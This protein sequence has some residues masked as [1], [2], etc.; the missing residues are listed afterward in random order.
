[1]G[2]K[3]SPAPARK[4]L[5]GDAPLE[6]IASQS[7]QG[8]LFQPRGQRDAAVVRRDLEQPAGR[9]FGPHSRG[10]PLAGTRGETTTGGIVPVR[11]GCPRTCPDSGTETA[12]LGTIGTA[13]ASAAQR[14]GDVETSELDSSPSFFVGSVGD[15]TSASRSLESPN[16]SSRTPTLSN[17]DRYRLHI[18]RLGLPE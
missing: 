11:R 18:L 4:R 1:M 3:E 5:G 6:G 8:R 14:R 16:F 7:S 15:Y 10:I 2:R 9:G 17:S 12:F 13:S